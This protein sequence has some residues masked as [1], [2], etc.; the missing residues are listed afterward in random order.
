M[1][2]VDLDIPPL[3]TVASYYLR[4]LFGERVAVLHDL[5]ESGPIR[6]EQSAV[7]PN[8]R[9]ADVQGPFDVFVNTYSFQEM[10]PDVVAHYITQVAA[11]DVEY[12]VSLN[13]RHGKPKLS[14]G[15]AIGVADPVTSSY[16][17]PQF[18]SHGYTLLRRYG[19]PLLNSEGELT[20][21][22]RTDR[23]RASRRRALP[24]RVVNRARSIVRR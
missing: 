8:W 20:V 6:V 21:L 24:R 7:L 15:H 12:V 11:K 14:D 16:V 10:E 5:P 4:T 22:R 18:E 9:I 2:Y 3:M 17:V 19:S 23:L 13:S 1:R